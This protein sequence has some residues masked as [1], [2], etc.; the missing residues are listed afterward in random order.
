MQ[1]EFESLLMR[2]GVKAGDELV[3]KENLEL[4]LELSSRFSRSCHDAWSLSEV[5][6]KGLYALEV[7]RENVDSRQELPCIYKIVGTNGLMVVEGKDGFSLKT[8]LDVR[9]EFWREQFPA[10]ALSA[11]EGAWL[12]ALHDIDA[13]MDGATKLDPC[14]ITLRRPDAS[15]PMANHS[16]RIWESISPDAAQ[17]ERISASEAFDAID[18]M[19]I[20]AEML[21]RYAG[22]FD[23]DPDERLT[24]TEIARRALANEY[25]RGMWST[26][27]MLDHTGV[28]NEL[29][30]TKSGDDSGAYYVCVDQGFVSVIARA[31]IESFDID[32]E[33]QGCR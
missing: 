11:E 4:L 21:L 2:H 31:P 7:R 1:S 19:S 18:P 27:D 6:A 13:E 12:S 16:L 23:V 10:L 29:W 32:S 9:Q 8:K 24:D 5:D 3:V 15:D 28:G 30:F 14:C 20:H 17:I 25:G 22:P 26:T 33:P